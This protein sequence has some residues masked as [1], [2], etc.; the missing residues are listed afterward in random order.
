M[1]ST[2]VGWRAYNFKFG[3]DLIAKLTAEVFLAA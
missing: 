2:N 1:Y 3:I